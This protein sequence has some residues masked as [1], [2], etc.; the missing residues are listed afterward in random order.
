MTLRAIRSVFVGLHRSRV[1]CVIVVYH[2][3]G[4]VVLLMFLGETIRNIIKLYRNPNCPQVI[5]G[6]ARSN[7]DNDHKIVGTYEGYYRNKQCTG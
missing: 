2:G 3:Y 5:V 7:Q 6:R 1:S 4:N